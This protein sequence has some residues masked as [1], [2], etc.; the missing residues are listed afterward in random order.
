MNQQ[1]TEGQAAERNGQ[2]VDVPLPKPAMLPRVVKGRGRRS[3]C[4]D[5]VADPTGDAVVFK[6]DELF[7]QEQ[8]REY[9]RDYASAAVAE[10]VK[11]GRRASA[12]ISAQGRLIESLRTSGVLDSQEAGEAVDLLHERNA[13]VVT[14]AA[15]SCNAAKLDAALAN[16]EPSA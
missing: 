5:L 15:K 7:T 4:E 9:A 16:M 2:G 1:H 8:M 3:G 13:L 12:L 11:A 6:D 10:L 14:G